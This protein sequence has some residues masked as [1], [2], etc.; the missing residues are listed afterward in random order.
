MEKNFI[1]CKNCGNQFEGKFCNV[2]G[3]QSNTYRITWKEILHHLPHVLFHLD[4]GI[5]YSIKELAI[6]PGY[7]IK[8]YLEG[9]RKY[10]F[11]PFLMLLLLTG[12]S[13]YL[14]VYLH[15]ETILS[16]VRLDKLEIQN[17]LIAHKYFAGQTIFF[18]LLCSFGDYLF[19]YEKKYTLPEMM[20][21]NVFLFSEI[22]VF[23]LLFIPL[24]LL[25]GYLNIASYLRIFFVILVLIYM[26]FARYQFY[27]AAANK[28]LTAKIAFAI[29]FYL[30]IIS[31]IGQQ[32]VEPFFSN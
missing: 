8:E 24:L 19:F 32:L 29:L 7:T 1:F 30:S 16:S 23:Q 21:A 15:F 14:Y 27:N 3:Q 28:M 9:K 6:R 4:K 25:G 22:T 26:F 31:L 2:C 12:L 18:C 5:L 11:N 10:H 13:S 20:V 17:A